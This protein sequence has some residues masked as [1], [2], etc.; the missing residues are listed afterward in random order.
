MKISFFFI[1]SSIFLLSSQSCEND[2]N[3]IRINGN[4]P[5]VTK[6]IDLSSFSEIEHT[7]VA[8][9]YITI[10]SPQSVVLKAQQNIIDVMT[11]EVVDHSLK[12]GLQEHVS[13]ETHDEI[14]FDITVPALYNLE[15]TGVG[16]FVVSGPDQGVLTITL[17][18]VGNIDSYSLKADTCNIMLTGVGNCKV[19]ARNLL[20]GALSGVGNVYY[21]GNPEINLNVTGVG[22]VIDSN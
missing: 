19:F 18:G 10:G 14:R 2:K 21:K 6:I 20:S 15:L 9:Y 22:Q 4:G 1:S 8:D 17:T 13:I 5:V 16:D 7:G 11:W 12:V 3:E